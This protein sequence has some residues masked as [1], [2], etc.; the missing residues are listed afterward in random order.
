[1]EQHNEEQHL[2]NSIMKTITATSKEEAIKKAQQAIQDMDLYG[3]DYG[4]RI[5]RH[6]A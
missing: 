3:E 4:W 5:K 2:K 6:Q 1:M